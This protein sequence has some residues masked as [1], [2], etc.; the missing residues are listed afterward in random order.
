MPSTAGCRNRFARRRSPWTVKSV[1]VP[2]SCDMACPKIARLCRA[3]AEPCPHSQ[4][5][6]ITMSNIPSG[7]TEISFLIADPHQIVRQGIKTMLHSR[8]SPFSFLLAEAEDS[9]DTLR[10]IEKKF[11]DIVFLDMALPGFHGTE[12][13]EEI[14]KIRP[15][16]YVVMMCNAIPDVST[17]KKMAALGASGLFLKSIQAVE[18]LAAIQDIMLGR[19]YYSAAIANQLLA[20][21]YGKSQRDARSLS[22]VTPTELRVLKLIS[23]GLTSKE[24]AAEFSRAVR[25]IET[26]RKNLLVKLA[27]KKTAHLVRKGIELNLI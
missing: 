13:I 16:L 14:F 26:H 15:D 3:L 9:S 22:P 20:P 23:Q 21:I 27:A 1:Q 25:T 6:S 2:S 4:P 19:T 7:L 12:V 8:A 24:I 18:L 5:K 17:I 11:F 10:K